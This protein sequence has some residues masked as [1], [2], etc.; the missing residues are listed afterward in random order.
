MQK[1]SIDVA[2]FRLTHNPARPII[3]PV[4]KRLW[5]SP[6]RSWLQFGLERKD[7]PKAAALKG[8]KF[9]DGGPDDTD[10]V[11]AVDREAFPDTPLPREALA[12]RLEEGSRLLA[13]HRW[14]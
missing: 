9:R 14:Q 8:V 6:S 1:A 13:G 3:E 10:A 4:L 12:S 11:L 7:A 2:R 5:F